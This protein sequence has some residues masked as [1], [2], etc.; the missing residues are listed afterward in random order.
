MTDDS[1]VICNAPGCTLGADCTYWHATPTATR[2]AYIHPQHT[3]E[4]CVHYEQ[5]QRAWGD[6]PDCEELD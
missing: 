3:G 1:Q 2:I 5:R 6:G 4:H